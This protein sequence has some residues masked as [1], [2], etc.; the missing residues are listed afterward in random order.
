MRDKW[1]SI[2]ESRGSVRSV[3]ERPLLLGRG[4]ATRRAFRAPSHRLLPV[5]TGAGAPRL[6]WLCSPRADIRLVCRGLDTEL[7]DAKPP[8]D[9]LAGMSAYGLGAAC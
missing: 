1:T 2:R 8:L 5:P 9:E 7:M 4:I 3:L 6:I